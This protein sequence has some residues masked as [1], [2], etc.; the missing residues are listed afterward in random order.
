MP[1]RSHTQQLCV[2]SS[3]QLIEDMEV[4]FPFE[5][6]HHSGLLKQIWEGGRTHPSEGPAGPS[7]SALSPSVP[8]NLTILLFAEADGHKETGV[9]SVGEAYGRGTHTVGND[10][11]KG[12]PFEVKLDV[13]VFS[14]ILKVVLKI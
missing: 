12:G 3:Q 11:S 10:T 7:H 6:L 2:C 5:L 4:P 9:G 8:K 1:G 14:L 13:H